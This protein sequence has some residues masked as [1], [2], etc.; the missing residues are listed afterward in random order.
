[1]P[2]A[3]HRIEGGIAYRIGRALIFFFGGRRLG[4]SQQ[5]VLIAGIVKLPAVLDGLSAKAYN[6]SING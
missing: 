6:I 5:H 1:M 2:G 4:R 3:L